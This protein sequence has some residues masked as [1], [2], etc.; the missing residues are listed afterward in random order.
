MFVVPLGVGPIF[1]VLRVEPLP[2]S[3]AFLFAD[4][5]FDDRE[6]CEVGVFDFSPVMEAS[7]WPICKER[8]AGSVSTTLVASG[9]GGGGA[10]DGKLVTHGHLDVFSAAEAVAG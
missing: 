7:S 2:S 4:D 6:S 3:S 10:C 5:P 1:G 9:V 8:W